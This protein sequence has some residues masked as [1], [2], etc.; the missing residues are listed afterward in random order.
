MGKYK[1]VDFDSNLP[2]LD[3]TPSLPISVLKDKYYEWAKG[4][5]YKESSQKE[6]NLFDNI[7][8]GIFVLYN[9]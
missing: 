9:F 4:M 5:G 6:I 2:L 8:L 3:N 7:F 1:D